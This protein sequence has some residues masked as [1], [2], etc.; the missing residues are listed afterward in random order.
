MA[1]QPE[2]EPVPIWGLQGGLGLEEGPRTWRCSC[3]MST[4]T[5]PKPK[6]VETLH[7]TLK[8]PE[9]LQEAFLVVAANGSCPATYEEGFARGNDRREGLFRSARAHKAHLNAHQAPL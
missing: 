5:Q 2:R 3:D 4:C 6:A 7:A 8:T 1:L 9:E